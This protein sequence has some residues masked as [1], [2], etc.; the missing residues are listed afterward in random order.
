MKPSFRTLI[1]MAVSRTLGQQAF[2]QAWA[3]GADPRRGL[4]SKPKQVA[5][6]PRRQG[7]Q[8]RTDVNGCGQREQLRAYR[9]AQGGPGIVRVG[10]VWISR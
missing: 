5:F 9:R 6:R 10:A 2:A 8:H 4:A 7:K 1:A 3:V